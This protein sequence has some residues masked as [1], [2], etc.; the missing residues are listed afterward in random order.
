MKNKTKTLQ[1]E[2]G[3]SLKIRTFLTA[4][5]GATAIEYAFIATLVSVAIIAG[6]TALGLE[7]GNLYNVIQDKSSN[8]L[9]KQ[10]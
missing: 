3:L 7:I 2:Q 10:P 5:G 6:V 1:S 8:A 9:G 4:E